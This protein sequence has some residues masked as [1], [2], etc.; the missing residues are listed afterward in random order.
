M[1]LKFVQVPDQ[2]EKLLTLNGEQ[3][4]EMPEADYEKV[5]DLTWGYI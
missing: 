4:A 2:G 5:S 3:P 1:G